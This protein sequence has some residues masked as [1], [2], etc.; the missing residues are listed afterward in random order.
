VDHLDDMRAF[1]AVARNGSFA[2]AARRLRLSPSVVTRS[3]ARLE[4]RLGLTLLVRTTRSLRLTE[5]GAMYLESCR[6][7]LDDIDNAERLARGEDAEPSGHLQVAA[8]ILFGRLHV[9]PIIDGLLRTHRALAIRLSLSD[10][11][12]HLIDE[13][14]DVGVR[15]GELADSSLIA[16][17]LGEVGR[18]VVA[19][20]SYLKERGIPDSPHD[21][22]RHDIV[23]F[24][25]LGT[26]GEWRFGPDGR[27]LRLEPRLAVNTADAAIAAAEAG[28]G[29]TRTLSYQVRDAVIAGRLVP[30]LQKFAPPPSPV[31]AIYPARRTASANIAAFV[32]T[33]RE[34]FREHP[35]IPVEAWPMRTP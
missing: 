28:T 22:A 17:R 3:I 7:I 27:A 11:N 19:S 14:I 25:G 34:Y 20:P 2:E 21:L 16:V 26:T 24:E 13:G 30:V 29:L 10:R 35:L 8:P 12:V 6:Q 5:R 33:A 23:A 4:D 1:V 15:I 18:V 31:S 32:K 9:L